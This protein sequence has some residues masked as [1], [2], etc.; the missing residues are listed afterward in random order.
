[1]KTDTS[2]SNDDEGSEPDSEKTPSLPSSRKSRES[3]E[4][5]M[6]DDDEEL[7]ARCKA[8]W[9]TE[10]LAKTQGPRRRKIEK[11]FKHRKMTQ[12]MRSTSCEKRIYATGK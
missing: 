1:M 4:L 12:I 5:L 6:S 8:R 7:L 2:M 9:E 10:E 11:S 3:D